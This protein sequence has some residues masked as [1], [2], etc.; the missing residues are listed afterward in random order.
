MFCGGCWNLLSAK[1]DFFEVFGTIIQ[2]IF[3]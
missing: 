1:M 2:K 3:T